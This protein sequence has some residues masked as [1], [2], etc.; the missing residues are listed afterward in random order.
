M[1]LVRTFYIFSTQKAVRALRK[2]RS[3]VCYSWYCTV[4]REESHHDLMQSL[5]RENT[6]RNPTKTNPNQPNN[7]APNRIQTQP[8]PPSTAPLFG[9]GL[10]M[11]SREWF[12]VWSSGMWVCTAT[13]STASMKA[14]GGEVMPPDSPDLQ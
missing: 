3:V 13:G 5:L 7:I 12:N 14:A 11:A 9:D 8:Q 4:N 10:D 2:R 6:P 1:A